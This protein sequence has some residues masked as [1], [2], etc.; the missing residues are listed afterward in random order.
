MIT[1]I[2]TFNLR[3]SIPVPC[4]ESKTRL[5]SKL[6]RHSYPN[7][8]PRS[9]ARPCLPPPPFAR[10]YH[11]CWHDGLT[12]ITPL[13]LPPTSGLAPGPCVAQCKLRLSAPEGRPTRLGHRALRLA[14]FRL[15]F[16]VRAQRRPYWACRHS[17]PRLSVSY[18]LCCC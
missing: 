14:T 2:H 5:D 18:K 4:P 12:K 10:E 6:S 3:I 8:L 1:I 7:R 15:G 11:F 13:T 17:S 9:A 16:V